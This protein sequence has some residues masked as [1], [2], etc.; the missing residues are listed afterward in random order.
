MAWFLL[1]HRSL[2]DS[3]LTIIPHLSSSLLSAKHVKLFQFLKFPSFILCFQNQDS[4]R[5]FCCSKSKSPIL[6]TDLPK[7]GGKSW[8]ERSWLSWNLLN[9]G[10]GLVLL[11][12][13]T[14][15]K[16][17]LSNFW[18]DFIYYLFSPVF[19][20]SMSCAY[21]LL[22]VLL[23]YLGKNELRKSWQWIYIDNFHFARSELW[24]VFKCWNH[25]KG[26]SAQI[27]AGSTR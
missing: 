12:F 21:I 8:L 9:N 10:G 16:L 1:S 15:T 3:F 6:F 17:W 11:Y 26:V 4:V 27:F 14:K 19:C 20:I 13:L 5:E 25:A 22:S 18:N 24:V 23:A 7:R 2:F